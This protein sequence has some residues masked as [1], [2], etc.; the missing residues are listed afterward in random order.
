[1]PTMPRIREAWVV[2]GAAASAMEDTVVITF[3]VYLG[4]YL[5]LSGLS[6]SGRPSIS[7][8]YSKG[9]GNAVVSFDSPMQ[10]EGPPGA[11]GP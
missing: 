4:V 10:R 2:A 7:S 6:A 8:L 9:W 5:G 1:M 3:L 11:G